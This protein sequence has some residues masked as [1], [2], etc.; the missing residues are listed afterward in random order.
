V[1]ASEH[2]PAVISGAWQVTGF[3]V[4]V[5]WLLARRVNRRGWQSLSRLLEAE[6]EQQRGRPRSPAVHRRPF[7]E[8]PSLPDAVRPLPPSAYPRARVPGA[9][10][11]EKILPVITLDGELVRWSC[12]NPR[13]MAEFDRSVAMY[14]GPAS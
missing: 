13:C 5:L 2:A 12:A 3:L 11:H 7:T 10:R 8:E 9:C 14:E 6:R 4:L 1:A